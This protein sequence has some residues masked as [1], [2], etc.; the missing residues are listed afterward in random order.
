M[1]WKDLQIWAQIFFIPD[2]IARDMYLIIAHGRQWK[3]VLLSLSK[4]LYERPWGMCRNLSRTMVCFCYNNIPPPLPQ[5]QGR[6]EVSIRVKCSLTPR[7]HRTRFIANEWGKLLWHEFA[8]DN[9]YHT[10]S[11]HKKRRTNTAIECICT[12]CRGGCSI[13]NF[14]QKWGFKTDVL[15]FAAY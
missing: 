9:A 8:A 5:Y 15:L 4:E 12:Q 13:T 11:A 10:Y 6:I 14:T 7:Q 1:R 2:N 3:L